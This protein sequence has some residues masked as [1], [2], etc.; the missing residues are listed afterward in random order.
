MRDALKSWA[1]KP[2]VPQVLCL[3]MLLCICRECYQSLKPPIEVTPKLSASPVTKPTGINALLRTPLFGD[4]LPPNI[5][6]GDIQQSMLNVKVVGVL[7]A[8]SEADSQVILDLA[9]GKERVFHLGDTIPGDA[10]IKRIT[11]EQIVVDHKGRL[12]RISLPKEDIQLEEPPGP[13]VEAP[14]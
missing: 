14:E 12:E 8:P 2:A 9:N 3:L 4:Y 13:L 1:V 5:Q 7:F 11:Q 10:V 6:E